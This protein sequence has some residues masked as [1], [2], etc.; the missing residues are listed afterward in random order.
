MKCV[1]AKLFKEVVEWVWQL[2]LSNTYNASG[3]MVVTA[4]CLDVSMIQPL[5]NKSECKIFGRGVNQTKGMFPSLF[6]H[7]Q[8]PM[9]CLHYAFVMF[10]V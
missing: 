9:V 2:S 6:Q 10:M 1:M 4:M 7:N 8:F 5:G 3:L